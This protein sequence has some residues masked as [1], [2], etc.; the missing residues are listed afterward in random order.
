MKKNNVKND[1]IEMK[2]NARKL[3]D[4]TKKTE[5]LNWMNKKN[6]FAFSP[7]L[8]ADLTR[9]VR[10]KTQIETKSRLVCPIILSDMRFFSVAR[11]STS[12]TSIQF[13]TRSL[14]NGKKKV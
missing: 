4:R 14:S 1:W 13:R 7:L 2:R 8:C 9:F 6:D 12:F 5:N 10:R 3:V 11:I